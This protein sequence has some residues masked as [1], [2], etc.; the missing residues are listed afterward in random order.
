MKT[1]AT[2]IRGRGFT[3]IEL[4]VVISII[5]LLIG[6]LL[7]SLGEAR[8]I[9]RM[10]IDQNN[11]RQLAQAS[12]TYSNTFQD[13]LPNFTRNTGRTDPDLSLP[14]TAAPVQL[15]AA[16]AVQIMRDRTG[17][18]SSLMPLPGAWI[19]HVLYS[20]LVLQDFM[21][22]RL[23]ERLVVSPAD[24][25]RLSWQRDGG[26]LFWENYWAPLQ[27]S[28][29]EWRWPFSSSYQFVPATY[30]YN[31]SNNVRAVMPRVSQSGNNFNTYTTPNNARLGDTRASDVAFPSNKV[32]LHDT[33]Q[34]YFGKENIYF[35]FPD[36]RLPVT[37]FDGS[38]RV[39]RTEGANPGWDPTR[40]TTALPTRFNYSDPDPWL[41]QPRP[42]DPARVVGYYRWTRGG[43]RGIDFNGS[44]IGTGQPIR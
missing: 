34:R 37:M 23:P 13:R 33:E 22:A 32:L 17:G 21:A 43:L 11:Q 4:L 12:N 5:A 19:P 1:E 9:A 26:R 7:P 2:I 15:A 28:G 25:V 24:T 16:Q 38:V 40:P 29:T 41:A 10:T 18:D 39:E 3:L 35:A 20:H 14:A 30:D 6:I 27:P 36:A 42:S 44:E 8:R 31:Q